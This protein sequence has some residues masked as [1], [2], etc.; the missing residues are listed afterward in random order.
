M[1]L[2]NR[3][4]FRGGQS[5]DNKFPWNAY[6]DG[7]WSG[8]SI[9]LAQTSGSGYMTCSTLSPKIQ[10]GCYFQA[11]LRSDSSTPRTALQVSTDGINYTTL[12]TS[13]GTSFAF[14]IN[15]SSYVGQQIFIRFY[16]TNS[17]GAAHAVYLDSCAINQS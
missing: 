7:Q 5:V 12:Q 4:N 15:L 10:D 11:S 16:C 1:A 9:S 14:N 2:S 6:T 8:K 3:I 17:G 13:G